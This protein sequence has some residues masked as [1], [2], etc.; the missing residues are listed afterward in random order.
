MP[1]RLR[2]AS[3]VPL[4]L[5]ACGLTAALTASA[6]ALAQPPPDDTPPPPPPPGEPA[7]EPLALPPATSAFADPTQ[8]APPAAPSWFRFR[9]VAELGFLF[10][11]SHKVQFSR[12]G[13]YFDYV[14]EGGQ[15]NL[16][17]AARLS[18]EAELSRRHQI[19]FLY[20]PLEI[21]TDVLLPRD[22]RVDGLTFPAGTPTTLRYGFPFYRLSYAY[23]FVPDPK[24]ELSFGLSMQIR[25]ATIDF[26]S[27]DGELFRSNRDVGP[28]P[29]LK[30]RGRLTL[31]SG[32]FLG[33]EVDGIYAPISV[34]NGSANETTGA[35]V[36][37]SLRA[38]LP[39]ISGAEA[40]VN[41][42]YLGGGATAGGDNEAEPPGDGYS[43][44]WLHLMTVTLG[45]AI[46]SP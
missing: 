23:D 33:Y 24:N 13:T 20:Q 31:E 45:A 5:L 41:L 42:R 30:S 37:L 3:Q 40:F 26:A 15:D 11:V 36:D 6:P 16:F 4:H 28:V 39:L 14:S 34:L 21:T 38:G 12:D 44:N 22:V 19:I 35:L 1:P 10:F 17:P 29:L 46:G 25:N 9:A 8:P 18:V 7:P 32:L 43:K 2:R 27:R